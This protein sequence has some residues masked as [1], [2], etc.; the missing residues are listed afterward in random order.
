MSLGRRTVLLASASA[1]V[2]TLV[3]TEPGCSPEPMEHDQSANYTPESLAQELVFR[4]RS[5]QPDAQI[6]KLPPRRK[7]TDKADSARPPVSKK[8]AEKKTAKKAV[9]T[10]IDD[11]I[12][13]IESKISLIKG[14]SKV[15][16]TK[17]MIETIS[18]DR[19]LKDAD[20]TTLTELVGRF[21]D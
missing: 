9:S 3:M 5:L 10:T 7:S 6:S 1:F 16:T 8:S 13:D 2:M 19:T 15:E 12:E 20:R 14:S 17:K 4:Y 11:V 18:A 21:D